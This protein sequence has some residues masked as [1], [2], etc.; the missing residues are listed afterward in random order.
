[1]GV[2]AHQAMPIPPQS[3]GNVP[4]TVGEVLDRLEGVEWDRQYEDDQGVPRSSWDGI[5]GKFTPKGSFS[6][7]GPK[8]VGYTVA[9]ALKDPRSPEGRQ[10]RSA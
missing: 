8:E 3:E 6:I 1:M 2:L 9:K 5:A 10:I 4:L 7:G